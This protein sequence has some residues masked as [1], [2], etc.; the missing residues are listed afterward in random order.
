M[1]PLII[2]YDSLTLRNLRNQR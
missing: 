2:L 1:S